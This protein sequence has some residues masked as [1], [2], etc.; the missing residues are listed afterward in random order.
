MKNSMFFA[1][2]VFFCC[3]FVFVLASHGWLYLTVSMHVTATH[4]E[5]LLSV[6]PRD[7]PSAASLVDMIHALD[8]AIAPDLSTEPLFRST[9]LSLVFTLICML[10]ICML[11]MCMLVFTA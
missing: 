9:V 11:A 4:A 10:V 6:H 5:T 7:R 2:V 1:L 8:A 3:F